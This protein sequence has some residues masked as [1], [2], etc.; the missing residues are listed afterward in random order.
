MSAHE[1]PTNTEHCPAAGTAHELPP[2]SRIH[3]PFWRGSLRRL[4]IARLLRGGYIDD[5]GR[6]PR[7][8]VVAGLG[9]AGL[10]AP[11]V[12]YLMLAPV[13]FTS[14]MA[15]ILPG[16]G[17]QSSVNLSDIGQASSASA[18]PY[19]S[20]S[21]SPTVTYKNLLMSRVTASRAA[22]ELGIAV[23]AFG[24]PRVK[25]L[26]QTSLIE[27][28][29]SGATP[30]EAYA[31]NTALLD[32]LLA[33]LDVLRTDEI[34]RREAA[35]LETTQQYQ[36]AVE[37]VRAKITRLQQSSRLISEAQYKDIVAANERLRSS[38]SEASVALGETKE[39]IARLSRLLNID[40]ETAAT[41][42]R[43]HTDAE[44]AALAES[45]AQESAKFA[46]IVDRFGSRHPVRVNA[47]LRLDGMKAKMIERGTL[48][49]GFSPT[50]LEKDID[51]IRSGE[52]VVLMS[53]L[54][55]LVAD[56]DG[57]AAK[58]ETL[59][60]QLADGE[61]RV[62]EYVN[63]ASELDSLQR[64]YK[65]AEAVFASAL[66]RNDTTKSDVFASYPM[67]QV[68]EPASMPWSPSSPK[69][70]I[71]IA[72]GVAGTM[73]LIFGLTLGWIRRPLINRLVTFAGDANA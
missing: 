16:A 10:W 22:D 60:T 18:S 3:V 71:A 58:I 24:A 30:E 4:S 23:E 14:Q 68:A 33:E 63:V 46:A 15:L 44:F 21:V 9:V 1:T 38:V 64:D 26:D 48:V 11:I 40:P 8:A 39:Q 69:R 45:L 73:M 12:A 43:L 47:Q 29:I 52:R 2:R 27:V 17:S 65:V 42:L 37:A 32:A 66:A 28:K 34:K 36:D 61:E 70:I 51:S 49:T 54:V 13:S 72:A 57:L 35:T 6:L 53:R 56:H 25:L 62:F 20:S 31:R 19:S 55:S 41:T 67:V 5:L 50:V 7:Y 59:K